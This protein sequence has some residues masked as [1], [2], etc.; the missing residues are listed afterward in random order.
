MGAYSRFD[1]CCGCGSE[2]TLCKTATFS[3]AFTYASLAAF[4]SSGNWVGGNSSFWSIASNSLANTSTSPPGGGPNPTQVSHCIDLASL[5]DGFVLSLEA[6]L[7][8]G[9]NPSDVSPTRDAASPGL[10]LCNSSSPSG[11]LWG[12]ARLADSNFALNSW[13]YFENDLFGITPFGPTPATGDVLKIQWTNT[14]ANKVDVEV[15]INGGSEHTSTNQDFYVADF[16]MMFYHNQQN[17]PGISTFD[18]FTLT[19]TNPP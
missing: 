6:T 5:E 3:E 19:I 8:F 7:A 12:V 15:F 9:P 4:L 17:L 14:V 1:P 10:M 2:A 13:Y 11:D 16:Y 18:N